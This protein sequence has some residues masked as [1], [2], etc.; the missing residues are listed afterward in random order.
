WRRTRSRTGSARPMS[1]WVVRWRI[2]PTRC[3]WRCRRHTRCPACCSPPLSAGTHRGDD[4]G[5]EEV[6]RAQGIVTGER[7]PRE[8]SG[9]VVDAGGLDDITHL[10]GDRRRR[11]DEHQV[12]VDECSQVRLRRLRCAVLAPEPGEIVIVRGE[13]GL[14][15]LVRA[16]V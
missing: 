9:D 7:S 2:A 4:L 1:Y 12:L 6:D 3:C 10:C 13:R 15:D 11:A 5:V 16:L 14:G 8:R